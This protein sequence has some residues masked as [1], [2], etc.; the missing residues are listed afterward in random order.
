MAII[1]PEY[2]ESKAFSDAINKI[3]GLDDEYEYLNNISEISPDPL[4]YSGIDVYAEDLS[5]VKKEIKIDKITISNRDESEN[6]EA[7]SNENEDWL[8]YLSKHN[9]KPVKNVNIIENKSWNSYTYDST[10]MDSERIFIEYNGEVIDM[11]K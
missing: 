6:R 11:D 8:V 1:S 9:R 10:I 2:S 5:G 7:F 3:R 4:L